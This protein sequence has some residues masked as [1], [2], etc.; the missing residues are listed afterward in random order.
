M[1]RTP[2]VDARF[3]R[4]VVVDAVDGGVDV[5]YVLRPPRRPLRF[6]RRFLARHC[7]MKKVLSNDFE[8]KF[9]Y[10]LGERKRGKVN[11]GPPARQTDHPLIE[12]AETD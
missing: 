11:D 9:G 4:R 8:S 10:L 5:E 3:H 12:T 6:S 2:G 1:G 7:A